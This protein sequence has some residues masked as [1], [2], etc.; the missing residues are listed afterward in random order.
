MA[1]CLWQGANT[2]R[3]SLHSWVNLEQDPVCVELCHRATIRRQMM[4][5]SIDGYAIT[6]VSISPRLT[7]MCSEVRVKTFC[8]LSS[9]DSGLLQVRHAV[10]SSGFW[11]SAIRL[12]PVTDSRW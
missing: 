6:G 3:S 11:L 8:L 5:T 2:D 9:N 10:Q 1:L 4:W 12:T 7:A